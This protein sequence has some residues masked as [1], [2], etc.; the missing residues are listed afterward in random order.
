MFSF[1][2]LKVIKRFKHR[3][4]FFFLIVRKLNYKM[5][6][7]RCYHHKIN[8]H[9]YGVKKNQL[10][11]RVKEISSQAETPFDRESKANVVIREV[12]PVANYH[13][14][15]HPESSIFFLEEGLSRTQN[16]IR[17]S[18]KTNI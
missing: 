13:H 10:Q 8:F 7:K 1:L 2:V 6:S 14:H 16:C 5:K 15:H 17:T 12:V 9:H 3:M 4:R 11:D 18:L